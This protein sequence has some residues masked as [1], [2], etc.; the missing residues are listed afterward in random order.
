MPSPTCTVN[1]TATTGGV[2]VTASTIVT[3]TLQSTAGVSTWS[4]SCVGTDDTN[5]ASAINGS[6]T[7]NAVAQTASFTAP[8]AGSALVFKSVVNGG[9]DANGVVQPS[10][11]TTFGIYVL[12][13]YGKRVVAVN[14]TVEG[15]GSF[16]WVTPVN[17]A[18]RLA[19]SGGGS[20]PTGTG[21]PHVIAGVTQA[22][23]SLI[24]N[25][26]VNAAAAIAGT[27]IS[28]DF[29]AQN[30][31]TTGTLNTGAITGSSLAAGASFSASGAGAVSCV[32]LTASGAITFTE[33][34]AGAAVNVANRTSDAVPQAL[35]INGAGP[36]A[37]AV[38]NKNSA[39]IT[40]STAAP[41]AAG[42]GGSIT[43]QTATSPT[44]G[45][46]G[47]ILLSTEGGSGGSL[48]VSAAGASSFAQKAGQTLTLG[49]GATVALSSN[50]TIAPASGGLVLL[51]ATAGAATV[52]SLAHGSSGAVEI[53]ASVATPIFRAAT[54]T[55]D[56]AATPLTVS[57]GAPFATAT[58]NKN[59][60]T[61]TLQVPQPVSGGTQGGLVLDVGTQATATSLSSTGTVRLRQGTTWNFRN[62]ANS[63]DLQLI[64][65]G[66]SNGVDTVTLGNTSGIVGTYLTATS[67]V[68]MSAASTGI[69]TLTTSS[70]TIQTNTAGLVQFAAVSA[71]PVVTQVQH[72]SGTAGTFTVA[73]QSA[74]ATGAF[75]GGTLKLLG[76]AK[77]STGLQGGVQLG[78]GNAVTGPL[79]EIAEVVSGNTVIALGRAG[80]LTA[81][82]M[83]ANTGS[84]VVYISTATTLP[85]ANS[86][87]G[88]ILYVD[89]GA[90][91]YRGTAGTVTTVAPA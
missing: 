25:A 38:T 52:V 29:G 27:K 17:A 19:G 57:S 7:V 30:I 50:A 10:Y 60:G 82:Q 49:N 35:A 63:A 33:A 18:I 62:N 45:L 79:I 12:T 41:L 58:T 53:H 70:V 66:G 84:G 13:A 1:A 36:W 15:D 32:S 43:I 88:G 86:V 91:K 40:I 68:V 22:A 42:A 61:L 85:T 39:A 64:A 47:S 65:L 14:E 26:D 80:A 72:A 44:A 16:G 3:I 76:G 59:S 11:A 55:A 90:L 8:A 46:G 69:V 78:V 20:S 28:P 23:A 2:N 48:T 31:L 4:I 24:V 81:T 9:I 71:N 21:I 89:A 73:A 77:G 56:T 5:T 87:G 67:S 37:S 51:G 54:Q 6:L 83:P 74:F 34:D 75:N